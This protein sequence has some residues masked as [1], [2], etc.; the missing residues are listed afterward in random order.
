MLLVLKM[1]RILERESR[2]NE[3]LHVR[4]LP[5]IVKREKQSVRGGG[6]EGRKEDERDKFLEDPYDVKIL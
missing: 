3:K 1:K 6:G 4:I 5:I 2:M